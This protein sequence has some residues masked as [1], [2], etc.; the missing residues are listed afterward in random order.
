M[1][2]TEIRAMLAAA[3]DPAHAAGVRNFFKEPVDPWGVRTAALQPMVR[4][5]Y[6]SVKKWPV[7]QRNALC[8]ELWR[9]KLEE[10]VLVCHL[11]RRFARECGRCEFHLFTRWIDR[12][13]HNWAHCDGVASWL[14]A[15]SIENDPSLRL[16]LPVWTESN[17][18]WKRRASIV[19]LLQEA[20]GGRSSEQILRMAQLLRA[21]TDVM[22]QKGVGWVLKEAYPQR[23]EEVVEFLRETE[24][25]RLV[26]RYAAEKMSPRDRASV[27][28]G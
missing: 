13:V 21:D 26:V 6:A 17:N 14:L 7:A 16:E 11:Y 2:A 20:K 22:V 9:G 28:L 12:Y 10:G 23:T 8:E 3:A 19:A 27:G 5:V 15:A 4:Q 18:R 1:T 24:F 25:P